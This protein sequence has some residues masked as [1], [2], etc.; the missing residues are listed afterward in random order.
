MTTHAGSKA[1]APG[2]L[3]AA[4][5]DLI[6]ATRVTSTARALGV[7]LT[8][9][10]NTPALADAIEALQPRLVIIDLNSLGAE[11]LAAVRLADER[12]PR[13]FVLAYCAH[14]DVELA[15]EARAAGANEVMPR[16]RF[17]AELSQILVGDEFRA[18]SGDNAL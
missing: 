6:F 2:C 8:L 18:A 10:T 9:V 11:A 12:T 14:V 13:P 3:I 16:S 5:N 1:N 15:S 7:E 4:I 17:H